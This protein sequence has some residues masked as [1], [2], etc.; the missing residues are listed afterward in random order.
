MC[1]TLAYRHHPYPKNYF[2]LDKICKYKTPPENTVSRVVIV[3][4]ALDLWRSVFWC[5]PEYI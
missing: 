5:L 1:L 4:C 2:S 3:F